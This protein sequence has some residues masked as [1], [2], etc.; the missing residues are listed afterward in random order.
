MLLLLFRKVQP[1]DLDQQFFLA[2]KKQ[3]KKTTKYRGMFVIVSW[4]NFREKQ[5]RKQKPNTDY[6]YDDSS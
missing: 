2:L 1:T 6:E 4:L 3:K 5:N